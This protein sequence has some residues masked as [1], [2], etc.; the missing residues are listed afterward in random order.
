MGEPEVWHDKVRK[1]F[2]TR[3]AAEAA[4]CLCDKTFA[5]TTE[6][7]L[8]RKLKE[9]YVLLEGP[10]I[11]YTKVIDVAPDRNWWHDKWDNGARAQIERLTVALVKKVNS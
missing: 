5:S 2:A 8:Q 3:A 6:F 4:L 9:G 10:K 7:L 11:E 1:S